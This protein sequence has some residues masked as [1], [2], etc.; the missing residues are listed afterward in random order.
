MKYFIWLALLILP[1][2]LFAPPNPNEDY[3]FMRTTWADA[4]VEEFISA[5][6]RPP[7]GTV[8]IENGR[9]EYR[10]HNEKTVQGPPRTEFG[11]GGKIKTRPGIVEYTYC[12]ILAT[13]D[14]DGRIENLDLRGDCPAN[15]APPLRRGTS[16]DGK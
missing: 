3:A 7:D 11:P 1:G 2:C 13:A 10:W 14:A 4:P 9:R 15:M 16:E 12:A 5:M 6:K 8:N